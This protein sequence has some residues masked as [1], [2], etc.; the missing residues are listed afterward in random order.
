MLKSVYMYRE[1]MLDP[2]STRVAWCLDPIRVYLL[3]GLCGGMLPEVSEDGWES[4]GRAPSEV[5]VQLTWDLWSL[6][7]TLATCCL[8]MLKLRA[9]FVAKPSQSSN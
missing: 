3:C 5:A 2:C 4:M 1:H 6:S 8:R 7:L 9:S